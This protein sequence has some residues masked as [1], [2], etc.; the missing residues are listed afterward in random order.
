MSFTIK[1][2]DDMTIIQWFADVD[3]LIKSMLNN[4]RDRYVRNQ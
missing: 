3:E 1:T 2:H 4:P